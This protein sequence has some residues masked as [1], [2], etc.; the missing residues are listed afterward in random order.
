MKLNILK[1]KYP[2]YIGIT[3]LMISIV[4]SLTGIF[5][6][7]SYKES[8]FAALQ[9]ADRLFDE[10]NEKV[11]ERYQHT[12]SSVAI[13]ASTA[14][15]SP[16]MAQP[17][18][19][20]GLSHPVMKLIIKKLKQYDYI[21]SIYTGFNDG[22]FF[23]VTAAREQPEI[24]QKYNAPDNTS[25][26]IR[27]I[28]LNEDGIRRLFWRYLDDDLKIIG[29]T[30]EM[31]V[32][33]DP[34]ERPWYGK[35]MKSEKTVFTEPYMFKT[36][37]IP[38]ITCAE[39]F[40]DNSGVFAVDITLK[41]F[42]QSLEQQKVSE[43]A[44][45]FL[46]N[47]KGQLLAHSKGDL[48]KVIKDNNTSDDIR[49]LNGEE[50]LDPVVNS[51]V[52][53]YDKNSISYNKT[54]LVSISG[55]NY[56]VRLTKLSKDLG[57]NEI[58]GSAAPLNDFTGHIRQMQYMTA[59]YSIIALL[60]FLPTT[61][62]GARRF[63]RSLMLLEREA[64]K[65]RQFDFSES[66]PF[67]SVIKEINSLIQAFQMMKLT[68]R[69]RTDA[70]IATQEKLEKLVQ[71]GIALSAE[72]DMDKLLEKI[73]QS[74][75]ELA[76][77]DG[78][79]LFLL[80]K[81]N[82]LHPEILQAH[83]Q[84]TRDGESINPSGKTSD[85]F[86][87]V[88]LFDQQTGDENHKNI[89]S[90]VALTGETLIVNDLKDNTAFNFSDTCILDEKSG[91]QCTSLLTVPLKPRQGKNIGVLQLFNA[92]NEKTDELM[93]FDEEIVRFVEALS[94]QAAIA[95]HNKNLLEAQRN[96]FNA[97][98]QLLAGA[99]DA[100]SPYTGGHCARVPEVAMMLAIAASDSTEQP[101][102]DYQLST[103]DQW[104]EFR[105]A[106]WL[107]DCGKV[108]TPEYVVDK[109]TKL[110]TIY[111]RIHEIRTRFEI[112]WRDAEISYYQK[113][114]TGNHDEKTLKEELNNTLNQLQTDFAFVAECNVGG[115]FMADEKIDRLKELASK[116]WLRH[117][118]D[119]IGLS[120]DETMLRAGEPAVELPAQEF[121]LA[122]K[123]EHIIPRAGIDPFD[124]NPYGFKMDVPE[125]L[126]NRGE[127]YNLC[128]KKGTLSVEERFKIN[129]HMIQTII[130]LKKLPF[131]DFLVNVPDFAGAHHETMDGSG[132]P[133]KLKKEDMSVSARIMA[134]ADIFEALTA[135]DRPYKKAKT[136]S[137]SLRIM[138]FM[139][140]DKHIDAQL[141]DLFLK[142]GVYKT[143]AEKFLDPKQI[144]AVNIREF[145]SND[146]A[147]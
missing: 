125:H 18:I 42:T 134:I 31:V 47:L 64:D 123:K 14:S 84:D 9:T 78:G 140:D 74:A 107:H 25:F 103:E 19:D 119:R 13:F 33:Y 1:R 79:A 139:R 93:R 130:M 17:P 35:A 46:F 111:N 11:S 144:D 122:D 105:I 40:F 80:D 121:L 37:R 62:I 135:S 45:M 117:F 65:V 22:S 73:F 66:A 75:Q 60:I 3:T 92:R 58:I 61:L 43:N 5:F 137:Q 101:F 39:K 54:H 81:E 110:E 106:A 69:Q 104:H 90:H 27:S 34:R 142:N 68:I 138:S 87:P 6:W 102:K 56:L 129:E 21:L 136:L 109:A 26:I 29:K 32:D 114:I 51:I 94:A 24:L 112:L 44:S 77:A 23:Q 88:S 49:F 10:I 12:L 76:H 71:S 99:I 145:L 67:D 15:I 127:L 85:S 48:A 120:E 86:T 83:F 124:G 115:E 116:K 126:Y 20:D 36:A 147:H 113:I 108:T 57:F 28:S 98:I 30:D 55:Q 4:V 38:G 128:I 91:S 95:L 16:A 143:Y 53:P 59:L 132:Y 131:P 89:E 7:I 82:H 146:T 2:F 50:V 41:R 96:L 63:S 100:K 118:D 70:L 72:Q 97:F 52:T 133:R 141:F 8:S